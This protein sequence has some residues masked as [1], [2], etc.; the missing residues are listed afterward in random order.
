M[1]SNYETALSELYQ[2]QSQT[3]FWYR[4]MEQEN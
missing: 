4:V 3:Y 2:G 1:I